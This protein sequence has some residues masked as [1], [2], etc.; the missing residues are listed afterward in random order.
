VVLLAFAESKTASTTTLGL[1]FPTVWDQTPHRFGIVRWLRMVI[2]YIR[3]LSA[4]L[5][6]QWNVI[7]FW[8]TSCVFTVTCF[9]SWLS[10]R[11][12]RE[13]ITYLSGVPVS[14]VEYLCS[15]VSFV[16]EMAYLG[17]CCCLDFVLCSDTLFLGVDVAPLSLSRI[18]CTVGGR[19]WHPS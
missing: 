9:S 10:R 7:G 3:V 16:W 1:D 6:S 8:A 18:L 14:H 5:L 15:R 13:E 19:S 4:A 17:F 2:Y 12:V 11:T